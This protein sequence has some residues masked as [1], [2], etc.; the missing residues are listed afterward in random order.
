MPDE[1]D[2]ES[3]KFISPEV[4]EKDF[5]DPEPKTAR[6]TKSAP[7]SA[8]KKPPSKSAAGTGRKTAAVGE[9]QES[10]EGFLMLL[11]LPLKMRDIH[12]PETGE[13]CGDLFIEFNEGAL[14]VTPEARNWAHALAVVGVDNKYISAIFG[15]GDDVGKW[16]QLALA[17]QVLFTPVISAHVGRRK[18]AGIGNSVVG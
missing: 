1:I 3:V 11:A 5:L 4:K 16:M 17:S 10:I 9:L 18:N 14:Q 2:F 12:D 7:R 13:S 8:S 15:M 6:P